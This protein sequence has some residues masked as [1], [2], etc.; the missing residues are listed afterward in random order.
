MDQYG[1]VIPADGSPNWGPVAEATAPTETNA[2]EQTDGEEGKRDSLE[3]TRPKMTQDISLHN[4]NDF[5]Y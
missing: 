2:V 1:N 3:D 5:A 4:M